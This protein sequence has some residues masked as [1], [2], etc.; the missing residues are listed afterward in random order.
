MERGSSMDKDKLDNLAIWLIWAVLII[1]VLGFL[2]EPF[3][4]L[5]LST[6]AT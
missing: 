1:S 6:S 5:Y 4:Y 3:W 2:A